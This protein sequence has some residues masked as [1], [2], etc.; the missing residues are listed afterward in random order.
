MRIHA[1]YAAIILYAAFSSPTPDHIRWAEYGVAGLLIIA[2]SIRGGIVSMISRDMPTILS[3]HRIFWIYMMAI[4]LVVGIVNGFFI[5]DIIRDLIPLTVLILPLCFY[6][7]D[8]SHLP[9][10]MAISGGL[11]ALRYLL[12]IVSDSTLLGQGDLLYLANAPLVVFATLMGFNWLSDVKPTWISKRLIGF[13]LCTIGFAAMGLMMQR[14]PLILS[15]TGCLIILGTR[16]LQKPVQSLIITAI[17]SI[18]LIPIFP[19][20]MDMFHTGLEKTMTVG[21]NNR[22]EEF[23]SVIDQSTIVGHGWGNMWQSPAVGD[24]W[25]RYTHNMISYYWLKSGIIGAILAFLFTIAWGW[26]NIKI[27]RQDIAMGLALFIPF[28]IHATLYT[29]FKTFDFALILTL[30]I[31]C[32]RNQNAS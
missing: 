16:A 9:T 29:G 8:L 31:L 26:Q 30:I 2:V 4:P 7:D 1:F 3:Y 22:A 6:K 11:F 19:L 14:A 10:I 27:F 24:M 17:I 15:A 32:S 23:K 20:V 12:P 13:I 18:A 5:Q 21:W 25:V 28:V